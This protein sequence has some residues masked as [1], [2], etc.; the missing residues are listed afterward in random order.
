VDCF[1]NAV[2]AS[3]VLT[4]IWGAGSFDEDAGRAAF[5][6]HC[7][8]LLDDLADMQYEA[9]LAAHGDGAAVAVATV[10]A[11]ECDA[12]AATAIAAVG[13]NTAVA[14]TAVGT[15]VD[16]VSAT[17]AAISHFLFHKRNKIQQSAL[18]S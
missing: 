8:D 4:F 3:V 18:Y 10:D 7:F 14:D 9:V 1:D 13:S 11:A 12:S 15:A 17:A 2:A 16:N 6:L 5:E